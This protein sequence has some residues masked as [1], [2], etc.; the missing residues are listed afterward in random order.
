MLVLAVFS[1]SA[2]AKKDRTDN[3]FL[4]SSDSVSIC[5][6]PTDLKSGDF[7]YCGS[8]KTELNH[9]ACSADD[10]FSISIKTFS[11]DGKKG[12][13]DDEVFQHNVLKLYEEN[14]DAI[15][16]VVKDALS[17]KIHDEESLNYHTVETINNFI[18]SISIS[19]PQASTKNPRA[20]T[21]LTASTGQYTTTINTPISISS[22]H[23]LS[24]MDANGGSYQFVYALDGGN[25]SESVLDYTN[26][27]SS[28]DNYFD[29]ITRFLT[30]S[31][32]GT[33]NWTTTASSEV[34]GPEIGRI[35]SVGNV[36]VTE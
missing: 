2:F 30:T 10:C 9:S 16:S 22:E 13:I 29:Q 5:I 8:N 28:G 14:K 27:I 34:S 23:S 32:G 12:S 21:E 3:V 36:F 25:G 11:N 15:K 19:Q 17:E 7:Y 1:G 4:F 20:I 26:H 31:Y 24:I 33:G 35:S 6:P 18:K